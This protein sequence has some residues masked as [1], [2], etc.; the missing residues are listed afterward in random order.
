MNYSNITPERYLVEK[1]I[2]F[3]RVNSELEF[4][5]PFGGCDDDKRGSEN[6]HCYMNAENG[7]YQCKKCF[8]SGN[9]VTLSRHFGDTVKDV[10]E[11]TSSIQKPK[12]TLDQTTVDACHAA[13]KPNM[14]KYLNERGITDEVIDKYKLGQGSFYKREWITIPVKNEDGECFFRLRRSPD[15]TEG[16]KYM[17]YPS[18]NGATLFGLETIRN[19]ERAIICEGEFDCMVLDSHGIPAVSS[20]AGA[21]TFKDEWVDK[22]RYLKRVFIAYDRDK[23]GEDGARM[24]AGKLSRI[25]GLDIFIITLPEAVGDH[26]DI[27]DFFV[28]H[29]GSVEVLFKLARPAS[30]VFAGAITHTRE[31]AVKGV[32]VTESTSVPSLETSYEYERD[33]YLWRFEKKSL[34]VTRKSDGKI[35]FGDR[36]RVEYFWNIYA[37]QEKLG[38]A[39]V[40]AGIYVDKKLAEAAVADIFSEL[41]TKWKSETPEMAEAKRLEAKRA[42]LVLD[43]PVSLEEVHTE[44]SKMGIYPI[45]LLEISMAVIFSAHARTKPPL[46]IMVIGNPSSIKTEIVKLFDPLGGDEVVY[47]DS[48]TENAFCS[49]FLPTDGSDP[50]DLLPVLNGKCL[51]IKDL[52]TTFSLKEETLKKI[53]GD[54]TS[55][56]DED[57]SKYTAT[58]G[59]IEYSSLFSQIGCVTP[60]VINKH[61][62]YMNQLGA[63]FLFY[64]IPEL[65]DAAEKQGFDIAWSDGKGKNRKEILAN[66]K[67]VA[68]SFLCQLIEKTKGIDKKGGTIRLE[69]ENDEI[70]ER[71]N[72]LAKFVARARGMVITKSSMFRDAQ[73]K[74]KHSYEVV[75]I[76]VEQPWRV[77]QQLRALSRHLAVVRGRSVV[78]LEEME[79]LKKVATSSMPMDRARVLALFQSHRELDSKTAQEELGMSLRSAQ[80][81]LKELVSLNILDKRKEPGAEIGTY[82]D[83][84]F[85][86]PEFKTI[87]FGKEVEGP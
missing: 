45:E 35:V 70:K 17:N 60:S 13:L 75:D 52:T 32:E 49:G 71:I 29:G 55:I 36:F 2:S 85:P 27:T 80:R 87:L 64:R 65:S 40:K 4:P 24:V 9:L 15:I 50:H 43:R 72:S 1:G 34:Q 76:Q 14:R 82:F 69:E 12:T 78:T 57:F 62:G 6:N 26:G 39:L 74:T 61:H 22:F 84:Y 53:L 42:E 11:I 20:T 48:M 59:S 3:K 47:V 38:K 79:T 51:V 16:E 28:K 23:Q 77:F 31:E 7:C 5:C 58:R 83:V 8:A 30:E 41:R 18:G 67:R 37:N 19:A 73:G 46:W 56:F 33:D 10:V 44:V 63:R 86:F 68:S 81:I 21:G 66:A 54:L 25:H